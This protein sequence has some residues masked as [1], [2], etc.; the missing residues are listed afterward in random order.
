MRTGVSVLSMI[1]IVSHKDPC[2]HQPEV[3]VLDSYIHTVSD[4]N[5]NH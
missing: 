2:V 4:Y 1:N 5:L 3:V